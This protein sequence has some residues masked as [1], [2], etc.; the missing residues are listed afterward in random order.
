MLTSR[1]LLWKIGILLTGILGVY[2]WSSG[3][4]NPLRE[5]KL[6]VLDSDPE[7]TGPNELCIVF[8]AVIG[9]FHGG[10]IPATDVYYWEVY[11][12]TGALLLERSGGKQFEQLQFSFQGPGVYQIRLRVRRNADF[13]F[14]G[15]KTVNVRTGPSLIIQPDYL[16]CGENPTA[17]SVMD[18]D[19][20]TLSQYRFQWKN[21]QGQVVGLSNT[22]QVTQEGQ[23][24]FEITSQQGGCLVTGNTF[25]G[26]SLDFNLTVS[27]PA[28]CRGSDLVLATDT[29]L[30]GEWILIRPGSTAREPLGE[31][32]QVILE[33]EDLTTLGTYTAIFSANDPNYPGCQSTRRITFEVNES[34]ILEVN[35]VE[36]PD[37]CSFPNGILDFTNLVSLD[38][39][40]IE[41]LDIKWSNL[42]PGTT[43]RAEDLAPQIYTL[44][45]Y[46]TGCKFIRLYNLESKQPPILLPSTPEI[47]LPDY[48]ITEETC[49]PNGINP[50]ILT[51]DFTQGNVSGAFRI[52]AEGIGELLAGEISDQ[53]RIEISV[54]GGTYL[55]EIKI[56]GCT[57]PIEPVTIA[58]RPT[59]DFSVPAEIA[60]CQSYDL[61]P[62]TAQDLIFTLTYPDN[63]SRTLDAGEAFD[64]TLEGSYSLLGVPKDPSSGLCPKTEEFSARLSQEFGF[65]AVLVEEDCFGNQI[66]EVA[67]DGIDLNQVSI[68]WI[69]DQGTIVGRN[70]KYFSTFTGDHDLIVQPLRSGFCPATPFE[71]T[72]N[73]PVLSVQ[74]EFFTDKICPDPGF[75][76]VRIET[77][78]DDAIGSIEWIY[79]DDAGNRDDLLDF[80]DQFAIQTDIPGNYEVVV[81][82]RIGCE[83]GREFTKVETSTLLADPALEDQYGVCVKN[84]RGPILNPGR[85]AEYRW[86]FEGN[87]VSQS[88]EYMPFETGNYALEVISEDGCFFAT[89]FSTYDLC[90]FEFR[91]TDAMIIGDNSRP[92]EAWINEGITDAEVFIINRQGQ[93]IHYEKMEERPKE[94]SV[95]KWDGMAFG[96][97]AIPGTYAVVLQVSNPT[98]GFSEKI[99]QA[100]L[101]IE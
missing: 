51:V 31:A 4:P 60:I 96:R 19:N 30:S 40:I 92:F 76:E 75:A 68:R 7:I 89:T 14:S 15:Q 20:P 18:P 12:P 94:G 84:Q 59:V 74:I 64:L 99:T 77:D 16:L 32:F 91:M 61:V 36:K 28:V 5:S 67:L 81:Y 97:P 90:F 3:N 95:F 62:S 34:P 98:Y 1:F 17:I 11:S 37:N 70:P 27:S 2:S 35:P 65:S 85:Y 86:Y 58:K 54:P 72:I 73:P 6:E 45:A 78:R 29:P 8:G 44:V 80:A 9:T 52:L 24:F 66:Y 49:G 21:S 22:L 56:D 13:I 39:L 55:L 101:V 25:V 83:V 100:L 63:T 82:N 71:F 57:Y 79:Y 26:P 48:S 42:T 43:V 38:S 53:D 87:M 47:F 93:L 50:G 41:E 10:G 46:S 33:R 88:S 23:Y 69:N